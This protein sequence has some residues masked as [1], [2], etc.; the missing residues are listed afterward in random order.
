MVDAAL[1]AQGLPRG[2]RKLAA[3]IRDDG[4]WKTEDR[5]PVVEQ[6]LPHGLGGDLGDGDG[7][8]EPRG[9]VDHREH[10]LTTPRFA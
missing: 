5:D 10:V 1:L 2:G 6:G 7:H 3:T 8:W 4:G 9:A